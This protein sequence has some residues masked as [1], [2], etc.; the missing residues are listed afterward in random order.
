VGFGA[1]LAGP[2]VPCSRACCQDRP[3]QSSGYPTLGF[4]DRSSRSLRVWQ[5]SL[6]PG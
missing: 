5:R 1:A 3:I 2:Y 4:E 6:L